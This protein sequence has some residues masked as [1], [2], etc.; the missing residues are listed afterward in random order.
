MSTQ[1]TKKKMD[2]DEYIKSYLA[3]CEHFENITKGINFELLKKVDIFNDG[4]NTQDEIDEIK[5]I[6]KS[7]NDEKTFFNNEIKNYEA[8]Y[9]KPDDG[10]DYCR[11]IV[12]FNYNNG[13]LFDYLIGIFEGILETIEKN[14][15][16]REK[17]LANCCFEHFVLLKK[18]YISNLECLQDIITFLKEVIK[19]N[20]KPDPKNSSKNIQYYMELKCKKLTDIYDKDMISKSLYFIWYITYLD[21]INKCDD[22]NTLIENIIDNREK[23]LCI[24]DDIEKELSD[25]IK[26]FIK[27][28]EQFFINFESN[29]FIL[30]EEKTNN[31]KVYIET[32][33]YNIRFP[34]IYSTYSINKVFNSAI[35]NENINFILYNMVANKILKNVLYDIYDINY[36]VTFPIS[37]IEKKEKLNRLFEII[38]NEM[39]KNNIV[40]N[41]KYSDYKNNKELFNEYISLGYNLSLELDDSFEYTENNLI[42]LSIFKYVLGNSE[43]IPQ[44][45]LIER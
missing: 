10:Y 7:L 9:E 44:D 18:S 29:D 24:N 3:L 21:N 39:V 43:L 4:Y 33:D 42:W 14:Y 26:N 27:K 37:I 34:K 25:L 8:I 16:I 20:I 5:K 23:I 22:V 41:I 36:I 35:I 11:L 15:Y 40:I 6:L 12:V 1:T 2:F 30:N 28:K 32:I 17:F 45:K 13:V 19:P 31:K 38:D